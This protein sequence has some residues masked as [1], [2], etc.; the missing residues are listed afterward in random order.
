MKTM[1]RQKKKIHKAVVISAAKKAAEI[2]GKTE[3]EIL[4]EAKDQFKDTV[5]EAENKAQQQ[6]QEKTPSIIGQ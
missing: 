3:D 4:N 1:V 6:W 5:Q 2:M